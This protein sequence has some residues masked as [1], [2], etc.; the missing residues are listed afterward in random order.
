MHMLPWMIILSLAFIGLGTLLLAKNVFK[1]VMGA[2]IL[3]S[4]V[5][6]FWVLLESISSQMKGAL[7]G[8][9]VVLLIL[10]SATLLLLLFFAFNLSRRY[11]TMDIREMKGH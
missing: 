3:Q 7:D 4:S 1:V 5:L 6:L 11:R 9:G 10:G 8:V 2:S